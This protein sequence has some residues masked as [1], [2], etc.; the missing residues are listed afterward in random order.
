MPHAGSGWRGGRFVPIDSGRSA[1]LCSDTHHPSLCAAMASV[2]RRFRRLSPP[3]AAMAGVAPPTDPE[4]GRLSELAPLFVDLDAVQ[5]EVDAIV[6]AGRVE[7]DRIRAEA[8]AEAE[9]VIAYATE[10]AIAVKTRESQRVLERSATER[11]GRIAAGEA[12]AAAVR[13]NAEAR[14]VGVADAV[15]QQLA[16]LAVADG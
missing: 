11:D 9:A 4:E 1:L 8:A 5:H 12:R 7:A 15:I 2:L 3:G 10:R 6:E 14:A 16:A 13:T